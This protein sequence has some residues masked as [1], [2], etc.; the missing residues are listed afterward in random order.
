MGR[1]TSVHTTNPR[2]VDSAVAAAARR[3]NRPPRACKLRGTPLQGTNPHRT[4]GLR[5]AAGR[6]HGLPAGKMPRTR[7]CGQSP[8]RPRRRLGRRSSLRPD[9][10]L[11]KIRAGP[12]VRE[13]SAPFLRIP[14]IILPSLPVF[15][16]PAASRSGPTASRTPVTG[17]A[18]LP[19]P[20]LP[21]PA[22]GERQDPRHPR[23][24]APRSDS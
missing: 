11:P 3:R 8:R 6:A 7:M 5:K 12:T 19:V 20:S 16:T 2:C 14:G 1:L 10:L 4:Y 23:D 17:P 24:R 22:V 15:R 21:M 18:H 9:G 13:T